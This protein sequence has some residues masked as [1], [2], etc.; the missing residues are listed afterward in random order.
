[1]SGKHEDKM[2]EQR[3]WDRDNGIETNW[4]MHLKH[5]DKEHV[6]YSAKMRKMEING[7]G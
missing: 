7:I 3:M 6:E 5:S 4:E 1:M 2:L